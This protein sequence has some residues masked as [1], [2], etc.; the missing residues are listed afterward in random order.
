MEVADDAAVNAANSGRI[1]VQQPAVVHLGQARVQ[2][3]AR[4]EQIAQLL[5]LG[6]GAGEVVGAVAVD[7]LLDAVERLLGDG[8]PSASARRK[9]STHSDGR[10]R[11]RQ[12]EEADAVA[13][14]SKCRPTRLAPARSARRLAA[15]CTRPSSRAMTRACVK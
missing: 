14:I 10:S 7:V 8:Q 6:L 13:A 12:V 9:I 4:I 3:R 11:R 1:A 15:R 2:A 5:A